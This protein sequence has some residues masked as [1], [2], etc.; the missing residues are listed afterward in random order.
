HPDLIFAG[1]R[2]GDDLARH[3]ASADLFLF[4]SET[5]TFGNVTLEAMASG[6]A[7]VAYDLAA[8]HQH[9]THG[10][11][12]LLAAPGNAG[13]FGR[14]ATIGAGDPE[15]LAAVGRR[16]RM[17]VTPL[18]WSDVARRFAALLCGDRA[19]GKEDA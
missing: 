16:A 11:D 14:V 9:I 15:R 2:V 6:L 1:V 5:D 4:P 8:A 7:V 18:L 13:A 3:Y 12:G 17:R 10:V 19:V